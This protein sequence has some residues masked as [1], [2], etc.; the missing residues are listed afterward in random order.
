VVSIAFVIA[1]R[2]P[3]A[4]FVI[5]AAIGTMAASTF[6]YFNPTLE[7]DPED[8]L[9][10]FLVLLLL[11]VAVSCLIAWMPGIHRNK[12]MTVAACGAMCILLFLFSLARTE[13]FDSQEFEQAALVSILPACGLLLAAL[14]RDAQQ[15]PWILLALGPTAYWVGI[16]VAIFASFAVF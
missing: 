11:P 3:V 2:L 12:R 6:L 8:S 16:V 1:G 9:D 14:S 13:Q 4:S 10:G 15:W 7:F 5:L